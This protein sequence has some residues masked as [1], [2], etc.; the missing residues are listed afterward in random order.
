MSRSTTRE[1]IVEAANDLFY[2]RGFRQTSLADIAE[3]VKI[4]R[5]NFYHHFKT[6]NEI[7]D[8]VIEIR[9]LRTKKLLE[10]WENEGKTPRDRIGHYINILMTNWNKIKRYGCPVGTLCTELA[11]LNHTLQDRANEVFTLFRIW[12]KNQFILLG[13]KKD[14][15]ELALHVLVW[16]QGVAT[17]ANAFQDK[18]FV[19]RE[20]KKMHNWLNNYA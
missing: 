12:L 6:K 17:L 10:R 7:L 5:G 13:Q 19:A 8:A 4:S 1:H 3:V 15:D 14:A 16:S 20:I 2:Q 11:K 9:L 18:K